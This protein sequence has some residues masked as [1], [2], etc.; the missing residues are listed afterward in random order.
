MVAL[1]D[2]QL[3]S[4]DRLRDSVRDG[5]RAILLGAV[6]GF[7]K[8]VVAAHVIRSAVEKGKSVLFLAHRQELVYQCSEKLRKF[9]VPH[10]II[11]A[12]ELPTWSCS[13][14]VASKDTLYARAFRSKKIDLPPADLVIP[15]EAHRS[16]SKT[17]LRLLNHY[18]DAG[19]TVIG[20]TATPARGDGRGLGEFYQDIVYGASYGELISLGFLVPTRVFAPYRPNLKGISITNGDYNQTELGKRMDKAVLVGDI[21]ENWAG[22][23]Y[24]RPT[25]L[26]ASSVDHSLHCREMFRKHGVRT[27]HVDGKTPDD[28]RKDIFRRFMNG[29]I[30]VL[31]NMGICVE[32]ID[33]PLASCCVLA[34]PT[35]SIVLYK[36]M[37]GRTMRPAEGKADAIVLDHAGAVFMHGFPDYDVPWDISPQ[38]NIKD[39]IEKQKKEGKVKDPIVCPKCAFAFSGSRICPACGEMLGERQGKKKAHEEGTLSEL[40]R[41]GKYANPIE[42]QRKREWNTAVAVAANRNGTFGMAKFLFHQKTGQWPPDAYLPQDRGDWGKKVKDVYPGFLRRKKEVV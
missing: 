16:M 41:D 19:S 30:Q 3:D 35:R 10:G 14:Q 38:S 40:G 13:V 9:E 28:E 18:R 4:V 36:Q 22:V 42:A 17:W 12:G 20:L 34:R 26:F 6:T 7:G 32:G 8:T 39:S 15:D 23:A 29:D 25:I 5:N 31:C 2:C 21:Y 37:V 11:M 33:L 24:D 1:R 27:E